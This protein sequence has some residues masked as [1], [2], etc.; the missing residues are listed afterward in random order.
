MEIDRKKIIGNKFFEGFTYDEINEVLLLSELK[1]LKIGEDFVYQ[2]DFDKNEYYFYFV[3]LEGSVNVIVHNTLLNILERGECFGEVS[4]L[5]G[6]ERTAI[7][8]SREDGTEVLQING[9]AVDRQGT[10]ELR[11]KLMRRIAM[12]LAKRLSRSNEIATLQAGPTDGLDHLLASSSAPHPAGQTV[13][14]D[15]LSVEE[16][17]RLFKENAAKVKL[18]EASDFFQGFTRS[19][20]LEIFFF[21]SVFTKHP[22]C[23][24]IVSQGDQDRSFFIIIKGSAFVVRDNALL[25]KL[26][27]GD[28]FGEMS[29]LEGTPRTAN[30]IAEHDCCTIRVDASVLEKASMPLQLKFYKKFSQLLAHRLD[31]ANITRQEKGDT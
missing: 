8:K 29:I 16:Q 17:E 22:D 14:G 12:A 5:T 30:V 25:K 31:A 7:I 6:R 19:E 10:Q 11:Y 28:T 23:Q 27:K 1:R 18:M 3:I 24:K 21:R 26:E 20:I 13:S 4:Y 15:V 9:L 2:D